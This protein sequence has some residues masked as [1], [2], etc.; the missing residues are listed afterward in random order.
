MCFPSKRQRDN[1]TDNDK[2]TRNGTSS[3]TTK[4]E[5]P[6]TNPPTSSSQPPQL[7][8]TTTNS[9][10]TTMSSPRVAILIYSM[11][12]HIAKMA[13]SVKAGVESAGGT[14]NIFQVPETLS[15]EILT[16]MHA[17]PK[18]DYPIAT[19]DTLTQHDAFLLGIPTR[20]GNMP[21]QW[22]AF[23]DAT[24]QLWG[25]G[26]L[27]GKYAGVFVSTAGLGGGQEATIINTLSTFTH[28]GII[29]VP[30]GYSHAF[31]DLTNVS[32]V[33]GGSPWGAGT[34]AAPDGSRQPSELELRLATTQGKAFWNIV[35]KIDL[36]FNSP[37]GTTPFS[38]TTNPKLSSHKTVFTAIAN[39]CMEAEVSPETN[40][41]PD[42]N[43]HSRTN[44]R[45]NPNQQPQSN[46]RKSGQPP[47]VGA[48]PQE[49]PRASGSADPQAGAS[50]S[51]SLGTPGSSGSNANQRRRNQRPRNRPGP[52][53]DGASDIIMLSTTA[54]ATTPIARG[55]TATHGAVGNESAP[56]SGAEAQPRPR[57]NQRNRRAKFGAALTEPGG[58]TESPSASGHDSPAPRKPPSERYKP[59]SESQLPEGDDLTSTLIRSL[60]TPPFPDCPIC[61]NSIH[62]AQPTWSCSPSTPI[63]VNTAQ[64]EE[65]QY[66]WTIF[67]VKCIRS[68]ASKSVKEVSEAWRARGEERQGDWRCPG[69]QVKR[70][71]V[72]T[73]YWCFCNSIQD[74]A[75][76]RLATPHSCGNPCARVRESG[77]GHPCPLLCHPGP[78]PPCQVTTQHECYCPRKKV[79]AFRCGAD[80][81]KNTGKLKARSLSC[82]EPCGRLLNCGKHECERVCHEGDCGACEVRESVRC[83]CGKEEKEMVCGE[84]EERECIVEGENA[85]RWI[86]RY[87]CTQKCLRL[88]DCGVHKCQKSCHVPS[89]KPAP[90]PFS[91]S[92]VI[93]CPCGKTPISPHTLPTANILSIPTTTPFPA[94]QACTD[95][96][97]TCQS[98]CSKPHPLCGHPCNANC[99]TG[100]CPPCSVILTRPCRCGAST[101]SIA[102]SEFLLPTFGGNEEEEP[103]AVEQE[104]LC[105]RPCMA[106]RACGRHQCRRICCPLASLAG[107]FGGGG[108]KGKKKGLEANASVEGMTGVGEERGGLHECDLVCGKMLSCGNHTCEEKDHKGPCGRCLRSSFEE[109]ICF[110][111][112]TVLE[113]PIP[114]GTVMVCKYPCPRPPPS[115]GHP[116]TPHTC[117]EDPSPCP[118]CVVLTTKSCACG[119]KMVPNVKCSLETVK[120]SCGTVCG[121]LMKCGFH[122]CERHCHADD[123]GDCTL[124]CGK[125]RKLCLPSNHPCQHPCHAPASCPEDDPCQSLITISCPC[126]RIRQSVHCGKSSANPKG[127]EYAQPKCTNECGIAKRNARLADALGINPEARKS[128]GVGGAAGAGGVTYSDDLVS[129]ARVNGKFLGIVEKAF[130]EFVNSDKR[131]QVLPHM[132]PERRKFVHD[133]AAVY[134]MDA[135]MVDQE[136]YRSVQLVRRIDTRIPSPLLSAHLAS[137]NPTPNLG[138]LADLRN[139]GAG[140]AAAA[141]STAGSGLSWRTTG[142]TPSAVFGNMSTASSA[143]SGKSASVTPRGWAAT[144]AAAASSSSLTPPA[145]TTASATSTP[146][147]GSTATL[148]PF[149]GGGLSLGSGLGGGSSSSPSSSSVNLAAA[150]ASTPVTRGSGIHH[151]SAVAPATPPVAS[152]DVADVPD[153]W[154]DDV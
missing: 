131:I 127:R 36:A 91:P 40:R 94:R 134:R 29:F 48:G 62:P 52:G 31:G 100:P 116:R 44:R 56:G 4:A 67:H 87:A 136:P 46:Q 123:C 64:G 80:K 61:F 90:C 140:G 60:N 151:T 121:K 13:E 147:L 34:L 66:C 65:V 32:E 16:K 43:P 37:Q 15:T 96:I 145:S 33:H 84:G 137:L 150:R 23:W 3:K 59:R 109:M 105:E 144:A 41:P 30:F 79:L 95:P 1:F 70:E 138:K 63:V 111:G 68:W 5:A 25:K 21:A 130:T 102:C 10:L 57:H 71:V 24:G 9:T 154:E 19:P 118:P 113:P 53:N 7:P 124:V 149:S 58:G 99:H 108:K 88:F 107:G 42:D 114:C 93:S 45:H 6:S 78:C 74:P 85:E 14:A 141:A 49:R 51:S 152:V 106:L 135:Q 2:P 18:G 12:G 126:G 117:H 104:I 75:L 55:G 153:D 132:P 38:T 98:P 50:S 97:P 129:F 128:G 82:G 143:G 47:P 110:C 89:S 72:P 119:K 8:T 26:A 86:G 73:G 146:R 122:H 69:C 148:G 76:T 101:K 142:S 28:H 120:V 81:D 11:Y 112:R 83:Y 103:A 35:S 77:C 20:Y 54:P 115:C 22:K 125:S 17:P 27:A 92:L 139:P 39:S 133:L